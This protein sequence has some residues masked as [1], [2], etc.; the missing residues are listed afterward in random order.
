[1]LLGYLEFLALLFLPGV[2]FMEL[3]RLGGEFSLAERLGLAFGLSMGLDVLVLAF[4]TS[5]PLVGSQLMVLMS[6][7]ST[8]AENM[9]EQHRNALMWM[10]VSFSSTLASCSSSAPHEP[11][12]FR[13]LCKEVVWKGTRGLAA[14]IVA[15]SAFPHS[16]EKHNQTQ[17][18][19]PRGA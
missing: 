11:Q 8:F 3:F 14:E 4:R 9:Y 7:N 19:P 10:H 18:T 13:T 17:E 12:G 16:S 5:G 15:R 6:S 2:A 1:L